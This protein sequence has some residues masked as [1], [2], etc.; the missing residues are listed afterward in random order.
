MI[1]GTADV[2][3]VDGSP[4]GSGWAT[5]VWFI[6][7]SKHHRV[8]SGEVRPGHNTG[9]QFQT[10]AGHEEQSVVDCRVGTIVDV[11]RLEIVP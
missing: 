10:A 8:D 1:S 7:S 4:C 3:N 6:T 11:E 5:M 2:A 9:R